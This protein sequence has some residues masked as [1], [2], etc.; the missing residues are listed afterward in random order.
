M[1]GLPKSTEFN[2]RI[3]KQKFYDN[4]N[5]SPSLKQ[6][7]ID[8]IKV[9]YWTNKI[10]ASTVNLAEGK[11]VTEIEV[12][13]VRLNS[14]VLD[15]AVLKQIDQEIP[16][17][18]LFI[19]EYDDKFQAWIG[20]KEVARSG[21][22][23]FK[24]NKYYHTEWNP[25]ENLPVRLEGLSLDAAY[26]NFVR[27]IAGQVLNSDQGESLKQSVERDEQAE[28]IK[29]QIDKLQVKI[30][31]EKQLNRQVQMNKELKILKKKLE[32]LIH[33]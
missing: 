31:R 8:N 24:V 4:L 32:D 10:A 27:Q 33:G 21:A 18:I 6:S 25:E 14:P 20:Y 23:A 16:Y 26:E 1:L 19:L 2:K 11:Y 22:S 28:G 13:K 15:E 7:F 29:K 9:I 30:R 17:H 3:P 5:I 12:F